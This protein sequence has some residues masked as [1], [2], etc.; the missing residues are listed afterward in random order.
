MSK[1]GRRCLVCSDPKNR[2]LIEVGL[3]SGTPLRVLA[4]RFGISHYA[5]G[6]HA[7]RHLSATQRAAVLRAMR[8]EAVDLEALRTDESAGVLGQI[9]SQRAR[10]LAMSDAARE[11]GALE[12]MIRAEAA[13]GANIALGA[14]LLGQ[15]VQRHEVTHVNM[16]LQPDYLRMRAALIEALRPFPAAAKAVAAALQ[17]IEAGTAATAAL[18]DVTP[19][20]QPP[21]QIEHAMAAPP[22]DV[23]QPRPLDPVQVLP[24]PPPAPLPPPP[25]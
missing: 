17:A 1:P 22:V 13:I 18:K 5:I 10:L 16:L 14:K 15:L 7:R 11:G 4:E 24:P 2:P 25:C 23:T 3:V 8:P 12:V 19:P 9:V 6:R 21:P 20:P